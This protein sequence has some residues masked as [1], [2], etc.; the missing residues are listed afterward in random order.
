MIHLTNSNWREHLLVFHKP[1]GLASAPNSEKDTHT[2]V[3]EAI[4]LAPE[5]AKIKGLKPLEHGLLHRLD[6]S[7]SGLLLFARSQEAFDSM[8]LLFAEKKLEKIYRAIVCVG[9]DPTGLPSKPPE[10][11]RIDFSIGNSAKSDAKV[12]V[13]SNEAK[14]RQI[15]GKAYPA[16]TEILQAKVCKNSADNPASND[17]YDLEI[18]IRTGVRHQIR[19]HLSS[20]GFPILGDPRYKGAPSSR[21]WL[22]A[23]KVV[24][25]AMRSL[26]MG[27]AGSGE[28]NFTDQR[29]AVTID[30]KLILE[31]PLPE[32]W[33]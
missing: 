33:P 23:W 32:D 1:S 3:A 4:K 27:Q 25:P 26:P 24:L 22:H 30:E 6:T 21:L 7:T 15:R 16:E 8:R 28:Y 19:A 29:P 5:I 10:P 13:I 12:V 31:S 18:L 17:L 14:L 20:V 11:M 2:A 9:P